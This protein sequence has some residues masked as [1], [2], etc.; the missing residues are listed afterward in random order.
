MGAEQGVA[1]GQELGY[2]EVCVDW[3]KGQLSLP[4][5][6]VL[7]L[8][9]IL[10]TSIKQFPQHNN[11]PE[12]DVQKQLEQIRANFKLLV[13]SLGGPKVA[14]EFSYDPLNLFCENER[15]VLEF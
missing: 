5:P 6:R 12:F 10:E 7:T 8:L 15:V 9:D 11:D 14:N 13:Q 1:I 2:Y 3:W 4:T